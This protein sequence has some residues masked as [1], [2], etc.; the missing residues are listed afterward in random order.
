MKL[1]RRQ[2]MVDSDLATSAARHEF[3]RV[4]DVVADA[5]G[6]AI[7]TVI[8]CV[9]RSHDGFATFEELAAPHTRIEDV[10]RP[11]DDLSRARH[12][13]DSDE[14]KIVAM[15]GQVRL[16]A[17][18]IEHLTT[19]RKQMGFTKLYFRIAAA[20]VAESTSTQSLDVEAVAGEI[21]GQ[22]MIGFQRQVEEVNCVAAQL[23]GNH[24]QGSSDD[25]AVAVEEAAAGLASIDK[26]VLD[27]LRHLGDTNKE[28]GKETADAVVSMQFQDAFRQR[29]EH[30]LEL[31]DLV[32]TIDQTGRVADFEGGGPLGNQEKRA[33]SRD[34]RRISSALAEACGQDLAE[35]L[36][37]L[38]DR[39][40]SLVL[41]SEAMEAHL[42]TLAD[43][44]RH[45][46]ERVRL[47]GLIDRTLASA[48]QLR[49]TL[50]ARLTAS[51]EIVAAVRKLGGHLSDLEQTAWETRLQALNAAI[52]A[53]RVGKGGE[54]I[55]TIA[56]EIMMI[57][58]ATETSISDLIAKSK[59]AID[60]F[61][62]PNAEATMGGVSLLD[63]SIDQFREAF[64]SL[65]AFEEERERR[66][67]S[68]TKASE[69]ITSGLRR[70]ALDLDHINS[71]PD[72]LQQVARDLGA[73]AGQLNE[74]D[75]Q[76]AGSLLDFI[77]QRY[78]MESERLIQQSALHGEAHGSGLP[79]SA[80]ADEMD[81]VLF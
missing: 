21:D 44:R 33:A 75:V 38:K 40:R 22:E 10:R 77:G 14:Q 2:P 51:E 60:A 8:S 12:A 29:M 7:K 78:T 49:T 41:R 39:L 47:F 26:S 32:S 9:E 69:D 45:R 68:L 73:Q 74:A 70:A 30:V 55:A 57:A 48:S 3:Q 36:T 28:I 15:A 20:N 66:V 35:T 53:K 56:T 79:S 24:H 50:G 19:L 61:M 17:S 80:P 81:L 42:E 31:L 71:V 59:N 27:T 18:D 72:A 16:M 64:G 25:L 43:D 52:F 13:I 62:V 4:M 11:I 37:E 5:F 65:R 6:G 23:A 67:S 58:T 63:S 54:A 34:L 1:L 46:E 76:E